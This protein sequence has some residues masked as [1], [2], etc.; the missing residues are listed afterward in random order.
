M[1]LLH[2]EDSETMAVKNAEDNMKE[3]KKGKYKNNITCLT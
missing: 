3:N 1:I 2:T